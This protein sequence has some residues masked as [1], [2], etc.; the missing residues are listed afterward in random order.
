MSRSK[1]SQEPKHP[2][3]FRTTFWEVT[4]LEVPQCKPCSC[5]RSSAECNTVER[6][7]IPGLGQPRR[8]L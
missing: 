5:C 6:L 4:F 7:E 1:V 3:L 8:L 2:D